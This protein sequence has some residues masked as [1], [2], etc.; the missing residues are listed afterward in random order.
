MGNYHDFAPLLAG[1]EDAGVCCS[2]LLRR[3]SLLL[4][5][6]KINLLKACFVQTVIK[7]KAVYFTVTSLGSTSTACCRFA[8]HWK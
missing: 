2:P 3:H 1:G 7:L 8:C 5:S 6:L 4:K